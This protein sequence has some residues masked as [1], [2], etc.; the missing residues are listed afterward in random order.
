MGSTS[1]TPKHEWVKDELRLLRRT[2]DILF[3]RAP[4]MMHMLDQGGRIANVNQQWL[5]TLGYK[6]DEVVGRRSVE[7]LT[8]ESREQLVEEAM[9]LFK[10]VGSARSVG[11]QFVASDLVRLP[12]LLDAEALTDHAG[13][14]VGVAAI[15]APEDPVQWKGARNTLEA[16]REL[17][18]VQNKLQ[19]LVS[20]GSLE[21]PGLA[22]QTEERPVEPSAGPLPASEIMGEMLER[23]DDVSA[24]LRGMLRTQEDSLD[25]AAEQLQELLLEVRGLGGTLRELVDVV[26]AG[27]KSEERRGPGSD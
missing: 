10:R 5:D 16:I 14:R 13:R 24:S 6:R 26:A 17:V 15:Y 23:A 7:F 18:G 21:Y 4:C 25:T 1:D 12:L 3:N 20:H 27:V 9:P 19:T 22:M 8:K 11:C 2:S